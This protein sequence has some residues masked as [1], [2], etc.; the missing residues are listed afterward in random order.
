MNID[1]IARD[2]KRK[3]LVKYSFFNS[4]N[5]NLDTFIT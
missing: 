4:N 1:I 3:E 5:I 2:Q